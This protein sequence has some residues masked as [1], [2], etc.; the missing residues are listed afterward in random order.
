MQ[1]GLWRWEPG[2]PKLYPVPGSSKLIQGLVEGD[3]GELLVS[4]PDGITQFVDGKSEAY[5]LL[6]TGRQSNTAGFL[7]DRDGGLWIGT[8]GRGLLHMHQ[9]KVD[10][11]G[12]ADGLSGDFV[13][14]LFEDH[15]GDIWVATVDG[16]D[17]FRD[18]AVPTTSVKQGLS[19][20]TVES[21]LAARDGSVWLG[22]LDGLNRWTDGKITI[23]RKRGTRA[24]GTGAT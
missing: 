8:V 18:F 19:N 23:Y 14:S 12:D 6:P 9:G 13:T 16:L 17:R 21:V 22:T 15:E 5:P 20:A 10:A 3:N 11:F 4:T 24:F 1:D 2:P 7:R